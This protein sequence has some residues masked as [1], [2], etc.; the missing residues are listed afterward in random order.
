M[1]LTFFLLLNASAP[2]K[3]L[4]IITSTTPFVMLRLLDML[5]TTRF[6]IS[7]YVEFMFAQNFFVM[8][9]SSFCIDLFEFM[10]QNIQSASLSDFI[11][12]S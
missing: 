8:L 5:F 4:M 1:P 7:M 3:E 10:L 2:S 11:T 12:L 6:A 9:L